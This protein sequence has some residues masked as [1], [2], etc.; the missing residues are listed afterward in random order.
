MLVHM[1]CVISKGHY[2]DV[3]DKLTTV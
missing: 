3:T 2:F 1:S